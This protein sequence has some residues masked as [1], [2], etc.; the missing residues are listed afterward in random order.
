MLDYDDVYFDSNALSDGDGSE[1]NP[2]RYLNSSS[3]SNCS[4]AHLRSGEYNYSSDE[5][6]IS[7]ELSFVGE[8]PY[9][10]FI[11]NIKINNSCEGNNLSFANITLINPKI[12]SYGILDI[13]YCIFTNGSN[14]NIISN[15]QNNSS[16]NSQINIINS[17]FHGFISYYGV[18]NIKNTVVT[19]FNSNFYNNYAYYGGVIHSFNSS[20]ILNNSYFYNNGANISGGVLYDFGL[21]SVNIA[22]SNF[23]FNYAG[24]YGGVI[25]GEQNSKINISNSDFLNNEAINKEGGVLYINE[26]TLNINNVW[27]VNS[28]ASFGGAICNLKSKTNIKNTKFINNTAIYDGGAIYNMYST[29]NLTQ[30]I[31]DNNTYSG[32]FLDNS[33]SNVQ[34]SKFSNTDIELSYENDFNID[35][36]SIHGD[37]FYSN[38]SLDRITSAPIYCG[39]YSSV[40]VTDIGNYDG[41]DYNLNT[42]VK[43]QGN[44]GNCWAF[45]AL[46]TLESCILKTNNQ[47]IFDLSEE[48]MKNII[49]RFSDYGLNTTTN[50]GGSYYLSMGYLS[51]WFG[52][53]L[54]SEDIYCPTNSLSP[55]LDNCMRIQNMYIIPSDN[56]DSIKEAVY[57][58]GSVY[59][60]FLC[61]D[62]ILKLGTYNYNGTNTSIGGHAVSIIGWDDNFS[63]DNFE[64]KPENN[65]AWIA[66]NSWGNSGPY[67]GYI[68]ISYENNKNTLDKTKF[69]TFILNDTNNYDYI[70]QYDILN[71]NKLSYSNTSYFSNNFT[72]SR[73]ELLSAV[74]TYFLTEN[75]NYT[76]T[77]KINNKIVHSQEGFMKNKG[78]YTIPLTNQSLFLNTNDKFEVIFHLYSSNGTVYAPYCDD[79]FVTHV[80]HPNNSSRYGQYGL[81]NTLNN[82]VFCI[83]SFTMVNERYYLI[84]DNVTKYYQG[85]E[86]FHVTLI[87]IL[88]QSVANKTIIIWINGVPYT[89]TTDV[90]GSVSVALGLNSGVY[91]VTSIFDN[92][93]VKS[94]VTILS[95]V[96]GTDVVKMFRNGTQYY[97]TFLNTEGEYLANGTTVRF[98][99]NGVMYNRIISGN[100]GLA[101]LNINLE[102]GEYIITTMNLVTGETTAN[103]ITVLSLLA[104]NRD[105]IKYYRNASQYTV[106]VLGEDGN[107]VGVGENVTFNIN[108]VFYTRTTN[109][110]GIVKLN[111]NLQPGDYIITAEYNGCS[112]SNYITVLPVLNAEDITMKYRDGTKF[113]ATLVDGQGHLYSS[114]II[115]FNINGVLYNR[116]TDNSGQAKLNINLMPGEYIITSSYNGC[117]IANRITIT[118]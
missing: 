21:S 11:H 35:N 94:T 48:N 66:K 44:G 34:F 70:Y 62:H 61:N 77:I 63:R 101:R 16:F 47:S 81:E 102:P 38:P 90:N 118:A 80:L 105:L 54:E 4:V 49:A 41:R 98:N 6:N 92:I 30:T 18:F 59:Y 65:G 9:N 1:N 69:F 60:E 46:A 110:F 112:V 88:H 58:Y 82:G 64:C 113:V 26:S 8:C 100:K 36:N 39:N 71:T 74:S 86:R 103:N 33:T 104:E 22:D 53:V 29:L 87:D 108:G 115:Q 20:L 37:I 50:G 85:Q 31:F 96:N 32:L 40:N 89:R 27:F 117:A 107:P 43:N 72:S 57:K 91:N 3:L 2:Y 42:S 12:N 83:K 55:I 114:Q 24:G 23:D 111:I 19:I 109:E 79:R 14:S 7:S 52:P 75:I 10:T 93:A 116:V 25:A 84:A 97:A 76:I 5:L 68:Y 45:A 67:G 15:K 56:K 13:R 78:Y 51:S 106:K 73:N 17:N 28:S 99:I 95:T